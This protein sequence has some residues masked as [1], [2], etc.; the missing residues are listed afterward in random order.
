MGYGA[1]VTG[2]EWGHGYSDTGN[3][4]LST[5]RARLRTNIVLLVVGSGGFFYQYQSGALSE[6]FADIIGETVQ[7]LWKQ[8]REYTPRTNRSCT[9]TDPNRRWIIGDQITDVLPLLNAD[10]KF[11]GTSVRLAPKAM[12]LTSIQRFP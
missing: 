2:H 7:L 12:R 10:G 5:T 8:P 1:D 9:L 3:A 6:S 4:A 11:Y